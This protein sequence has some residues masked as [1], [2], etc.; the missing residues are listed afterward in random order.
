[1]RSSYTADRSE[2]SSKRDRYV[3]V[4]RQSMPQKAQLIV[5]KLSGAH[6]KWTWLHHQRR[7]THS[8]LDWPLI[9][10]QSAGFE[11]NRLQDDG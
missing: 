7:L 2:L 6:L 11:H 1:M 8:G 5:Q 9:E 3:S 4:P 10:A